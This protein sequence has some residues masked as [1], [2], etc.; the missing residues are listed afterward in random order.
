MSHHPL[1]SFYLNAVP[2]KPSLPVALPRPETRKKNN[3]RR[4][5]LLQS[6]RTPTQI[7]AGRPSLLRPSTE[8]RRETKELAFSVSF[9][10]PPSDDWSPCS[11]R[12]APTH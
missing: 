11:S 1:S 2:G 8:R 6:V 9:L 10:R 7:E 3:S 4:S 5:S 12:R